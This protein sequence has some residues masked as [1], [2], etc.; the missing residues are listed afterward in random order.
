MSSII[1]TQTMADFGMR[2]ILK[3]QI[4]KLLMIE[5]GTYNEMYYRPYTTTITPYTMEDICNRVIQSGSGKVSGTVLAGA[6]QNILSP[7][8]THQGLIDIPSGWRERRIRFILEAHCEFTLGS[9]LIYYIQ[10]YTSYPGVNPSTGSIAPD[11]EFIIN[12]I[13][14]VVNTTLLTPVGVQSGSLMTES[15]QVLADNKW[16]G[17]FGPNNRYSMRPCDIFTGMQTAYYNG[18]MDYVADVSFKDYRCVVKKE[19]MKSNRMN[20][21]PVNYIGRV[22]EG[23]NNGISM[24]DFGQGDKDIITMAKDST[25]ETPIGENPI[26]RMLGD[27]KGVGIVNRFYYGDLERLD[28]NVRN[29]TNFTVFGDAQRTTIPEA[30][31][32]EYWNGSDRTTV[33]ATML[34]SSIPAIM[35]SL[36]LTKV[37]FRSTNHSVDG[38]PVTTIID[39]RSLITG[40]ISRMCNA[41]KWRLHNEVINDMTYN[42]QE[43]YFLDMDINIFG[44]TSMRI[45]LGGSQAVDYVVPTFCDTLFSP[46]LAPRKEVY[47]MVVHDFDTLVNTVTDTFN[48]SVYDSNVHNNQIKKIIGI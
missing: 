6:A 38:V 39:A 7:S 26:I 24:A 20:N 44:D 4:A 19:P 18:A 45:G 41:F 29:V 21:I 43:L 48:N 36:M 47:E 35:A 25:Y 32:T 8:A 28:P 12:S 27:I 16:N 13:E 30:G 3:F 37:T 46:V 10:G 15:F 11:M 42:N 33:V 1:E 5:T 14:T 17:P 40:D 31:S 34:S 23:Y 2:R 22:L 9:P